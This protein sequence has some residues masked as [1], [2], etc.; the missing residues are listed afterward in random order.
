MYTKSPCQES[1]LS[2]AGTTSFLAKY[3]C[4]VRHSAAMSAS[5]RPPR[6]KRQS[7]PVRIREKGGTSVRGAATYLVDFLH[8]LRV[9]LLVGSLGELV[10]VL[11]GLSQNT[12]DLRHFFDVC[13]CAKEREREEEEEIEAMS[14]SKTLQNK[15]KDGEKRP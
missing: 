9:V 14:I 15:N 4:G 11:I 12:E 8:D 2:F 5:R 7:V 1:S 13:E 6:N 10:E 3:C